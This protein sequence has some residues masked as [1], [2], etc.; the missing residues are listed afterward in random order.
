ML[1]SVLSLLFILS[2]Y[3]PNPSYD[4][5]ITNALGKLGEI[6]YSIYLMHPIVAISVIFIAKKID[7]PI[8][9]GY[10]ASFICV[11]L[12]GFI[13]YYLVEK[14]MMRVGA[15]IASWLKKEQIPVKHLVN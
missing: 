10:V 13:T 6:S 14:P 15:N 11:M 1:M 2:L 3:K 9:Y 4:N 8:G 12:V 5:I 7:I